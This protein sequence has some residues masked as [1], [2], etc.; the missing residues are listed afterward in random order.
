MRVTGPVCACNRMV[1]SRSEPTDCGSA[2]WSKEFLTA[3]PT[4]WIH[5]SSVPFPRQKFLCSA[6]LSNELKVLY[7]F[8]TPSTPVH[9]TTVTSR[10]TI[11]PRYTLQGT[12]GDQCTVI[13][14]VH[15]Q[16]LIYRWLSEQE[17]IFG[18]NLAQRV[19]IGTK[20]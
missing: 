18:I 4:P 2:N 16:V 17:H 13:F 10:Q 19:Y 6:L 7:M 9:T 5:A 15:C 3:K 14:S 20:D 8:I 1:R 12:V 11:Q